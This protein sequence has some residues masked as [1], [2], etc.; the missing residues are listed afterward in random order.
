MTGRS[1]QAPAV[2]TVEPVSTTTHSVTASS[3]SAASSTWTIVTQPSASGTLTTVSEHS[4]KN[5]STSAPQLAAGTTVL[6]TSSRTDPFVDGQSTSSIPRVMTSTPAAKEAPR[7]SIPTL[8]SDRDRT[9]SEEDLEVVGLDE[10]FDVRRKSGVVKRPTVTARQRKSKSSSSSV[11]TNQNSLPHRQEANDDARVAKENDGCPPPEP[12]ADSPVVKRSFRESQKI[13]KMALLELNVDSTKRQDPSV[14]N[15]VETM[16]SDG[17][18]N[19][20]LKNVEPEERTVPVASQMN[21][22]E[23]S[24]K[25]LESSA[26]G[27]PAKKAKTTEPKRQRLVKRGK[28]A[29][30]WKRTELVMSDVEPESADENTKNFQPDSTSRALRRSDGPSPPAQPS[31]DSDVT[32]VMRLRSRTRRLSSGSRQKQLKNVKRPSVTRQEKSTEG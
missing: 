6:T 28:K 4:A 7:F 9:V 20:T 17:S 25:N 21:A 27:V 8:P 19:E 23:H 10:V 29:K 13:A 32:P 11:G 14:Y 30:S 18:S 24:E 26:L 16:E 2:V 22:I 31:V 5:A 1:T 15:W 12:A 3:E